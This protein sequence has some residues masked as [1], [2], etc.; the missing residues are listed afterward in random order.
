MRIIQALFARGILVGTARTAQ[1]PAR[2]AATSPD[3]VRGG[4]CGPRGPGHPGGRPP[5]EQKLY[6][7]LRSAEEARRVRQVSEE[8]TRVPFLS[9]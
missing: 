7:R 2:H 4:F 3:A 1:L 5:G 6:S 9:S 8:L